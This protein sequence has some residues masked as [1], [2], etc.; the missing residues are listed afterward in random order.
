MGKQEKI[1]HESWYRIAAQSL[2]L[3]SS[4]RV[5]RQFFRGA[6]WYLLHD[7][8]TNNHF[9]LSDMAYR[10]VSR[11]RLNKTVEE[12]WEELTEREPDTALNQGEIIEL[13]AQL[14][15][16]NLLHYNLAEN[17]VKLFDRYKKRKQR[18]LKNTLMN[19]MFFRIPLF[20][21]DALLKSMFPLI[22]LFIGPI[23][24]IIWLIVV[25]IGAKYS[26]DNF[27]MLQEQSQ[28]ILAPSNLFFLYVGMAFI[29]VI[30]EFGHAFA[31][32]RFGGEVHT[33]GI[34]FLLFTPL[35]YVD[36]TAA[37][38]FRSKWYRSFVGAA[39]M[40]F[41]IFIA[42]IAAIVWAN[43]G[44][45]AI[46]S[47]AYNM[48]LVASV[49]TLLFNINPLLRFDGYYI[50]SDLLNIP[51][52]HQQAAQHLKYLI[53]KFAFG[54]KNGETPAE[55]LGDATLFTMF[56]IFST[57]YRFVV[58][59]GIL[60]FISEHF[61]L[62]ALFMG[63][64]V[65]ISWAV[66]P[67]HKLI[68]YLA[69]DTGLYRIRTRAITVTALFFLLI[70]WSIMFI[71]FP[72]NFKAPGVLK[73]SDYSIVSNNLFGAIDSLYTTSGSMVSK[74][75]TILVL[76]NP[77]LKDQIAE[78]ESALKEARISFRQAIQFEQA[79][80][81]PIQQRISVYAKRAA[82]LKG[83]KKK[84]AVIAEND[85]LW[86]SQEGDHFTGRWMPRGSTLGQ[87]IGQKEFDFTA[88]VSQKEVSRLFSDSILSVSAK[89]W[90]E[91][92]QTLSLSKYTVIP[93][94]YTKLPSSALGW[95]GGGD[96]A[97]DMSD[98][99]G[100]TV[101]EP[102]Y[103]VRATVV[104]INEVQLLHGRS[105]KMHFNLGHLPLLWQGW[106]KVRQMVQDRYHI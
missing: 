59:S 63:I 33:M 80:L 2:S 44:A 52:L 6:K 7:P 18:E 19:I 106:R 26:I 11:L 86:I 49:S 22:K 1:F 14:Y 68:K 73:S 45:G 78:T 41:E 27:D 47:I 105:G 39:G 15:H 57:L 5:K 102:F 70:L 87:L 98:E 32:R 36:A 58:F 37:W 85:G 94:E 95:S 10:F 25:G 29:K 66:M 104:P 69:S 62:L 24:L 99:T 43:T 53:E 31:V 30:H 67:I 89:L 91:T 20:D 3:R 28:G 72:H 61:L 38:A 50:L 93:M 54:K 9:R 42:A 16:S 97:V 23:G 64:S 82:F 65:F 92:K 88:V 17:S 55:S 77:E 51:N 34:M 96:I 40:F 75:D 79:D 83:L 48:I 103:E 101:V 60:L 12:V 13:L 8:F 35:P 74:G 81:K 71:P 84:L 56:K 76:Y 46:H 21:P 90:G 100:T 4:V